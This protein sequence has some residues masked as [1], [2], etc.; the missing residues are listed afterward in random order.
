LPPRKK[1]TNTF[2]NNSYLLNFRSEYT[3]KSGQF[4]AIFDQ[5]QQQSQ[6]C[7]V[8]SPLD[9]NSS[10]WQRSETEYFLDY[11]RRAFNTSLDDEDHVDIDVDAD[12]TDDNEED[13]LDR[14]DLLLPWTCCVAQFLR[15]QEERE[16][17]LNEPEALANT[18][19]QRLLEKSLVRPTNHNIISRNVI[20]KGHGHN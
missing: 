16:K 17:K 7:G 13:E 8:E 11:E 14:E 18:I 5:V 1:L 19:R 4:R 9:Y 12:D 2:S 6:C 15:E 20:M 10:F 3:D